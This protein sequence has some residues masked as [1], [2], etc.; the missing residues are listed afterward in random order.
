LAAQIALR[1]LEKLRILGLVLSIAT[2]ARP[3]STPITSRT[4]WGG[5]G[6]SVSSS[7]RHA[8]KF[9]P[10]RV[11]VSVIERSLPGVTRCTTALIWLGIFGIVIHSAPTPILPVQ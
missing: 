1:P 3:T 6:G 5:V 10:V 7:Y 2:C 11:F 8:A 9:L 4:T